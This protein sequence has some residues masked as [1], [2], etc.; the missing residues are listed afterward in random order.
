[1]RKKKAS[2][3]VTLFGTSAILLGILA[4]PAGAE[5]APLVIVT[6]TESGTSGTVVGACTFLAS[7]STSSGTDTYYIQATAQAEGLA[8]S[9]SIF[10]LIRSAP[11]L[12]SGTTYASGGLT[13]PGTTTVWVFPADIPRSA[14]VVYG[15]A[16]P[17][18]AFLDGT[19]ANPSAKGTCQAL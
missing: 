14:S 12:T 13:L 19:T 2:R 7:A 9:T 15:C 16:V 4:S 5:A 1:M 11:N 17:D 18:A 6:H 3:L 8:I 10:C